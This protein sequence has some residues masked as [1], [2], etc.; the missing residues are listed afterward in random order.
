MVGRLL[1]HHL[2]SAAR[3]KRLLIAR[4][5]TAPR[6]TQPVH[7]ELVEVRVLSSSTRHGARHDAARTPGGGV[8]EYRTVVEEEAS[9]SSRGRRRMG[10]LPGVPTAPPTDR[11]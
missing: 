3:A 6:S 5:P 1:N 8:L 2:S 9:A 10:C 7:H 11:R 4:A